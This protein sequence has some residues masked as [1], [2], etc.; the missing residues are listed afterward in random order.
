MLWTWAVVKMGHTVGIPGFWG[1]DQFLAL[2]AVLD[3]D[4]RER[5]S[6][7]CNNSRPS[8]AYLITWQTMYPDIINRISNTIGY[9]TRRVREVTLYPEDGKARRTLNSE[10]LRKTFKLVGAELPKSTTYG[11]CELISWSS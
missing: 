10:Q 8:S 11:W 7:S 4:E 5:V 3:I 1:R 9:P 6:S 2:R